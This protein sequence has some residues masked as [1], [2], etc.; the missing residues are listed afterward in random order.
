MRFNL[1][2]V[3]ILCS[4][5]AM[6]QDKNTDKGKFIEYKKGYYHNSILKGIEEYTEKNAPEKKHTY[7]KADI[8]GKDFPLKKEQYNA[9]WHNKP[10]SQGNAGTCWCYSTISFYESEIKRQQNLDVKLSEIYIVYWEYV[11]KARRYVQERGNSHFSEGS[12]AN[13]VTRMMKKYGVVPYSAYSGLKPGLKFHTHAEM[14]DEMETYLKSIKETASWNEEQ[15]IET[16][17]S[18]MNH[19]IGTP[20]EQ[21]EIDG[22]NYTPKEYLQNYLKLNPEDYVEI[23]SLKKPGYWKQTEYDVPDNWWNSDDYYNIPLDEFMEI[24]KKA[25]KKGYT[26]SI[27]GDVSEAGFVS[28]SQVAYIPT[29]DIPSEYIN[30]DARQFR[31]SNETTTDD[32]GVH[33]VGYL[34]KDGNTWYLIKDSGAGSRNC[35]K[36]DPNFGYYFFHEDF[37]KLKMMNYTIHKDMVK[38]ILKKIK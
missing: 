7:F 24:L 26:V 25:V 36:D 35:G 29:F 32:H 1:V 12:E 15:V 37:V 6:A 19:H 11:E 9:I 2:L 28:K 21:V 31:F 8:T 17:K 30:D 22:K 16:I 10:I 3:C 4:I 38:D 34:E 33:L 13:A 14:F 23:M 20:P 18:I 5:I 27:G